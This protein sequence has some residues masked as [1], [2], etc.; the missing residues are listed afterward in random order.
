[1]NPGKS[2]H[3]QAQALNVAELLRRGRFVV[4]WH[5]RYFDWRDD[6]VDALLKDISEAVQDEKEC[7]FLG[8]IMLVAG[9]KSQWLIN[10]GQQRLVTLSLVYAALCRLF[11]QE[12][13]TQREGAALRLLFDRSENEF[14]SLLDAD[15][16]DPRLTPPKLDELNFKLLVR[17]E[18][19]GTNG[20]LTQ[21]WKLIES[22][23][24]SM[25]TQQRQR[26]FQFMLD[27]I[28]VAVIWVPLQLD[29]SAV[30]ETLNC[31][32]RQLKDIDRIRNF[33]YSHFANEEESPRQTTVH[34]NL[35]RLRKLFTT[36]KAS[37]YL[38][39]H[40]QCRFGAIKKDRLYREF[41]SAFR[42]EASKENRT[43]REIAN[44]A[45]SLIGTLT[46]EEMMALYE[47]FTASNLN[48]EFLKKFMV[49][50]RT[51]NA[52][53]TLRAFLREL[54]QYNVANALIFAILRT[55]L[56][57]NSPEQ[58]RQKA[59]LVHCALKRLATFVLR[60]AFVA[61][62][63]EPS[64]FEADFAN[65]AQEIY[66][67]NEINDSSFA[68]F[69]R[70][71]DHKGG[72]SVLDDS[73]FRSQMETAFMP[74]PANTKRIKLFLLGINEKAQS[75][76]ILVDVKQCSVE[77]ILPKSEEHWAGWKE[78]GAGAQEWVSR[79][80]NMTL[81]SHADNL[82]GKKF[83]SSFENKRSSYAGSALEITRQI[84]KFEVWSPDTVAERQANLADAAVKVWAFD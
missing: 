26:Y 35:E 61:A 41:R 59:K 58:R 3:V 70:S 80:G 11:H 81:L 65:Y 76:S 32:G 77:H 56:S 5:Q 39:C 45:F 12:G 28:E 72:F 63:F 49:D 24:D 46:S 31:R 51:S 68:D 50:S 48:P 6:E 47:T 37:E 82:S 71:C 38:R 83:N 21:A 23:V 20:A 44:A 36:S 18:D 64:R 42:G 9:G 54:G 7:Y 34:E 25:T 57:A 4:P 60:T 62:K 40:L 8:S 66:S 33:L 55:Y 74:H 29:A 10:D 27:G 22:Y 15:T 30:F 67:R 13:D 52:R 78:F 79:L 19:V 14:S 2:P 1:M 17:G 53:R 73:V 69:L 43:R 75:D 16:F 84:E